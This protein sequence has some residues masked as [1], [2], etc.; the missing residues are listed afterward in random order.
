MGYKLAVLIIRFLTNNPYQLL[1]N[2]PYEIPF[3]YALRVGHWYD[4]R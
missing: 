3:C 4:H 2:L 1:E